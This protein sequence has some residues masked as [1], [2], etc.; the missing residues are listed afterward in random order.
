MP[1][2]VAVD[3][4]APIYFSLVRVKERRFLV[5]EVAVD[6]IPGLANHPQR[7]EW[8]KCLRGV[9]YKFLRSSLEHICSDTETD[10]EAP[11]RGYSFI[12]FKKKQH[13]GQSRYA[14]NQ[15]HDLKLAPL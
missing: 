13:G 3:I 8:D 15:V 4:P 9:L 5:R 10:M 11:F 12:L 1:T 6:L 7:V 14:I 2:N